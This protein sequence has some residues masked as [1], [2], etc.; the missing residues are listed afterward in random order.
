[1]P[2]HQSLGKR[3]KMLAAKGQLRPHGS[4]VERGIVNS[5]AHSVLTASPMPAAVGCQSEPAI[6]VVSNAAAYAMR[7]R[8]H[9]AAH[10]QEPPRKQAVHVGRWV[11]ERVASVKLPFGSG[12]ILRSDDGA[13]AT[14]ESS[15]QGQD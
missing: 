12:L 4:A 8:F 7:I 11:E 9:T 2:A 15:N 13:H 5:A 10:R 6:K 3:G 1:M 14:Q